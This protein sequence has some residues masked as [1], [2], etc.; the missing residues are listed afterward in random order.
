MAD[1]SVPPG[2]V[3]PS[4]DTEERVLL[5]G[6]HSRTRDFLLLL[7]VLKEFVQGFR[8]LHFVG[9]CIT[10]FGSARFG[11]SHPYY[12]LAREVG[13]KL[14]HLGFTVMTGG[15][16]GLMEGANRGAREAGGA[17]VA[18][19]IELSHEQAPNP[20]LDRWITC[21]YFFVRKVLLFKY[22]YGF[23]AL[24]GGIGTM[25]ELFEALTLIQTGKILNFPVVLMDKHYWIPLLDQMREMRDEGAISPADMDLV[26]VTDD[27]DE[28]IA[29]I[30]AHTIGHFGLHRRQKP[31]IL[32]GE[33]GLDQRPPQPA[34][35][36][37]G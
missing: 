27:V 25:D 12:K 15:G 8:A 32:L 16:P 35:S 37:R 3:D 14:T 36:P 20:Y 17:S 6:P 31:S 33:R 22:S 34:P 10:V 26:K 29:H 28:A 7:R 9:P 1:T 30:G 4:A 5:E 13:A 21:R 24:P 19:N 18:C 23:I 2:E 11:E